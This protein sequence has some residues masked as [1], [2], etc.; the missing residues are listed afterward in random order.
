MAPAVSRDPVGRR[1]QLVRNRPTE[2]VAR[3]V[4]HGNSVEEAELRWQG[5][6]ERVVVKL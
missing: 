2:F 6:R 4:G 3:K 5:A 1:E